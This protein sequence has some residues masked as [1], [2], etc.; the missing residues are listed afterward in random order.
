[1]L[2]RHV[3]DVRGCR[4][5]GE[6]I[7]PVYHPSHN[8]Q[9]KHGERLHNEAWLQLLMDFRPYSMFSC[10]RNLP[11]KQPA[12]WGSP[13]IP[14]PKLQ[15]EVAEWC[16]IFANMLSSCARKPDCR[17]AF[18]KGAADAVQMQKD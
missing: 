8:F 11:Y 2:D 14:C 4:A 12:G 9:A 17:K 15:I 5:D 18:W 13:K 10:V 1:M 6:H 16:K 7:R 3:A